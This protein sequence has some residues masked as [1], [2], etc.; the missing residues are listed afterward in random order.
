MDN[1][2]NYLYD[3]ELKTIHNYEDK[4]VMHNLY[5]EKANL[6]NKEQVNEYINNNNNE[7]ADFLKKK[8]S[9][10]LIKNAISKLDYQIPLYDV[11]DDNIFII[12]NHNLYNRVINDHYRFPD[13]DILNKIKKKRK[14]LEEKIKSPSIKKEDL[15]LFK[16]KLF[17]YGLIIPFLSNFNLKILYDTYI[18]AF[19]LYTDVVGGDITTCNRPSFM[20]NFGHVRPYYSKKEITSLALNMGLTNYSEDIEKNL[21]SIKDLCKIVSENDISAKTLLEHQKHIISENKVGLLQYYTLQGYSLMNSYLRGYI[22]YKYENKHLESIIKSMWKLVSGSPGFDKDYILY[23]F[24]KYDYLY[25]LKIGDIYIEKGFTSTT[26]NPF[27]KSEDYFLGFILIKINLPKKLKGYALCVETLSL[28]PQEEEII[29]VPRI[30]LRLDKKDSNVPY[31]HTDKETATN[32]KTRYEF[33]IIGKDD[34]QF[35]KR[36]PLE[37]KISEINFLKK[38]KL[39]LIKR[40]MKINVQMMI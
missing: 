5:Y 7:I 28:F 19:Y 27:Y 34:I 22:E 33:T 26:R 10:E 38:K 13:E 29:L 36:E 1:K 35:D 2:T 11:Y 39:N 30:K 18:K 25:D 17:K 16:R 31:Y 9:I 21:N 40:K 37:K 23:R 14:T 3:K 6:P 12:K 4:D 20:I 32:I 8:N 24:V 15:P